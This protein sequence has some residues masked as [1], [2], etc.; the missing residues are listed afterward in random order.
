[1]EDI[2]YAAAESGPAAS[3]VTVDK[4]LVRGKLLPMLERTDLSKFI[5]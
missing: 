1:M 5:L 2:S 4:E 3:T